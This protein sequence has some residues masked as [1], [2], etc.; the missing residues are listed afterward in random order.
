MLNTLN[1]RK[2]PCNFSHVPWISPNFP[3]KTPAQPRKGRSPG[4]LLVAEGSEGAVLVGHPIHGAVALVVRPPKRCHGAPWP[5][6][7][8]P[9]TQGPTHF[10]KLVTWGW[11]KF[12]WELGSVT[13]YRM[14]SQQGVLVTPQVNWTKET[15]RMG[16]QS[17]NTENNTFI[18]AGL[19]WKLV[20]LWLLAPIIW[21]I[22]D[23]I[24]YY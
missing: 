18:V 2:N 22:M 21:I 7:E 11:K 4:A 16:S 9:G 8:T 3:P 5:W 24:S 19:L 12:W 13:N 17:K 23:P 14:T 1:T 20:S 6:S 10:S 15:L